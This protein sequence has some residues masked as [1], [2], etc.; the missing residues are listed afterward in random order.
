MKIRRSLFGLITQ[1]LIYVILS[2]NM[3]ILNGHLDLMGF[4]PNFLS[5][6][7]CLVALAYALSVEVVQGLVRSMQKRGVLFFGFIFALIGIML[8]SLPMQKSTGSAAII[9]LG[10]FIFGFGFASVT[11]PVMP[12]IIEAIEQKIGQGDDK[13]NTDELYNNLAGYFVVCQ[14]LGESLG[15][16]FSSTLEYR[17]DFSKAERVLEIAVASFL[18]VYLVM[19]DMPTFFTRP[20]MEKD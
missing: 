13:V 2:F 8:T 20:K 5:V 9:L 19:C 16:L 12:E 17:Y 6:T 3:P 14:A 15:P 4:G 18:L 11:I 7:V 10:C 1:A